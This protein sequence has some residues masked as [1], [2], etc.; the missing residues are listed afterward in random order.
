MGIGLSREIEVLR[1]ERERKYRNI[2]AQDDRVHQHQL[3]LEHTKHRADLD[4]QRD[5]G[6][7]KNTKKLLNDP[8]VVPLVQLFSDF[9]TE[10]TKH[11]KS[12]RERREQRFKEERRNVK[13]GPKMQAYLTDLDDPVIVDKRHDGGHDVPAMPFRYNSPL[14]PNHDPHN[15]NF[16]DYPQRA[17]LRHRHPRAEPHYAMHGGLGPGDEP[18]PPPPPERRSRRPHRTRGGHH[19]YGREF[20]GRRRGTRHERGMRSGGQEQGG[21]RAGEDGSGFEEEGTPSGSG[22]GSR[23]GMGEGRESG[24]GSENSDGDGARRG[25]PPRRGMRRGGGSQ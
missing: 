2:D 3:N 20:G 21:S 23:Q 4:L 18:F 22:S 1:G 16:T 8:Q 13:S 6:T 5:R 12:T 15:R 9:I 14:R 19:A 24:G 7:V 11:V 25:I 17:P 10:H